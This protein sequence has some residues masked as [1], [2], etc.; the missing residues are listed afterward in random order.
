M[1]KKTIRTGIVGSGFSASFHFEALQK[2]YGTNVEVVG[3]HSLDARRRQG[4]RR[5]RGIR[6]F[7]GWTPC[8]TRST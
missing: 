2:V 8:W 1:N 6:F 7:D 3:V 4:I 5:K